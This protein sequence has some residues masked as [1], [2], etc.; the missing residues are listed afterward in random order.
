LV[1]T[2]SQSSW[3]AFALAV[4]LALLLGFPAGSPAAVPFQDISSS[5]PLTHVSIGNE[6]S[7]QV[8]H[9]GD[10]ALELFPSGSTPGSCGTFVFVNPTLYAPDFANHDGSATSSLGSYTPFT[11]VSQT[12]VSG[13]GSSANP[14]KVTTVADVGTTGLRITQ[15]DTYVVGQESY[16]TD[17]TIAN[18]GGSSVSGIIYRAGDCYLQGDDQGFG[19]V[20]SA[21]NAVGCSINANN[22]PAG[23]IEQW[24]P[25]TAGNQYLEANYSDGWAA[26]G[27][28]QPLGNL[29]RCNDRLD[30]WSGISWNFNIPGGGRATFSHY[31]TFSPTGVAG[32]P[33]TTPPSGAP[34]AFGPGGV[35]SLPSPRRCTSR[36]LFPIKIRQVRGFRYDFATVYVN[37]RRVK[38]YYRRERRWFR[39]GRLRGRYINIKTF[40]AYV[41]LR[42]LAKGRYKVRIL[43]VT[44][45]GAIVR[46]TRT[47]RT[48]T[49]KLR[50]SV[51]RL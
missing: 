34:R 45:T 42:G 9:T 15:V 17:V 30:N 23:R 40:R 12:P 33:P 21:N 7:C 24:F 51:P 39:T 20:D 5:G 37:G 11:A 18:Q 28:H 49:R 22:S 3:A 46:G 2:R 29:C 25:L 6:L 19:F 4:A 47:Y 13:S 50:G 1:A 31:T 16:R 35:L 43:V 10:P 8:A 32:P 44:T 14:F 48:C 26:I 41:D 36:R 27:T 38:V